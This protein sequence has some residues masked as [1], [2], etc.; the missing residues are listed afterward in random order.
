[1]Y[2]LEDSPIRHQDDYREIYEKKQKKRLKQ[3]FDG[4]FDSRETFQGYVKRMYKPISCEILEKK[5]NAIPYTS[6]C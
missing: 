2:I 5:M 6:L 4:Y 1:M 3:E